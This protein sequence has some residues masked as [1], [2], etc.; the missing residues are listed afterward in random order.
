M[1][2]PHGIQKH[3]ADVANVVVVADVTDVSFEGSF[4]RVS[5]PVPLNSD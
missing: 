2:P 1:I 5:D 4:F 3:A